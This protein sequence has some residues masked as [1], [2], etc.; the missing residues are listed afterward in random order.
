MNSTPSWPPHYKEASKVL[1]DAKQ[2][3]AMDK[4]Q[5]IAPF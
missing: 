2:P 5:Y 3:I 1:I 4:L